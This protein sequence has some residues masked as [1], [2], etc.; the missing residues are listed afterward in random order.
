M[1]WRWPSHDHK[2]TKKRERTTLKSSVLHCDRAE[3]EGLATTLPMVAPLNAF[4]LCSPQGPLQAHCAKSGKPPTLFSHL[5]LQVNLRQRY[6][7]KRH[8]FL[9]AFLLRGLYQSVSGCLTPSKKSHKIIENT[10]NFY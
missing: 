6:K 9:D 3:R 4:P 2:S 7:N 8:R 1:L 10:T 5:R